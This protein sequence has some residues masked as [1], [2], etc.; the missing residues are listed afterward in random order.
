MS[1]DILQFVRMSDAPN[2][3]REL[4]MAVKM[5][6]QSLGDR[7]GVSKMTISDLERGNIKLDLDYMVR[8][9]DVLRVE[10]VDLLPKQLNP[11]AMSQ[12]ER[13][14]LDKYRRA[15]DEQKDQL[16]RVSDALVPFAA[17]TPGN[18]KAA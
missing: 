17:E 15:T 13:S 12:D 9:A 7:I 4:R 6:Q 16:Q 8:I 2:R 14:Y 3:I 10:V 1:A 18:G 11:D 5:S